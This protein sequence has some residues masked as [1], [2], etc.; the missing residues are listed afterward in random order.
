VSAS[1]E[2]LHAIR[3]VA[4]Q[5]GELRER[6]VFVGG[7]VRGLLI[8]DAAVEGSRPTKDV[9]LVTAGILTLPDYYAQIHRRLKELGFREDVS[10]NVLCRWRLGDLIVDVMP[11]VSGVL[12]FSNRWYVHATDT[13]T[14]VALPDGGESLAIRLVTAPSFLATKLEAFAGRGQGNYEE[15]H[16]LEDIIALIDG[17]PELV[18]EVERE[19]AEMR[20]YIA[21]ALTKH[22]AH[23][24]LDAV[25][26]HLAG[27]AAS[28]SRLPMIACVLDRLRRHPSVLEVGEVVESKAG[29]NPGANGATRGPWRYVITKVERRRA[30]TAKDHVVVRVQLTNLGHVAGTV[31]DGRDVHIE[32]ERGDR[33]PPLYKLIGPEL[34]ALRLPQTDDQAA[35]R[36]PFETCWVYEVRREA[37]ALRLLLPFDAYELPL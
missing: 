6:V 5:L 29:G 14:T 17:R 2:A 25:P 9:D 22:V 36:E 31:G 35:P 7:V 30:S 33:F 18:S 34:R 15:S 4:R 3:T 19:P 27:D 28:Q 26:G 21:E 13:A 8:T 24:L 10:D 20:S 37:R 16:D 12:G 32:D 1:P 11:P 23:G